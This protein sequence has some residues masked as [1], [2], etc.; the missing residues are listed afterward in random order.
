MDA[1][2]EAKIASIPLH[3][4]KPLN[5]PYPPYKEIISK[6]AE[7][8]S[9]WYNYF[10]TGYQ[11]DAQIPRLPI[12]D[13]DH[14]NLVLD[15]AAHESVRLETESGELVGLVMR[16]FCPSE[17]ATKWADAMAAKQVPV[18]RNIRVRLDT[19]YLFIYLTLT[20]RGHRNSGATWLFGG[21]AK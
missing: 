20:E 6:S 15:I 2:R 19:C 4:V 21:P 18:R 14:S 12:H 8:T 3:K 1:D 13:L 9:K 17:D 10:A 16:D 5:T 7:I 11:P